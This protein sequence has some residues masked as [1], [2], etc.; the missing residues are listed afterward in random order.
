MPRDFNQ[1]LGFLLG[2][3]LSFYLLLPLIARG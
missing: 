1:G 3:L 2:F